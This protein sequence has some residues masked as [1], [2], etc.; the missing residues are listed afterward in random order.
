[1]APIRDR[2]G[3]SPLPS[4]HSNNTPVESEYMR[5]VVDP[6]TKKAGF[7]R[8]VFFPVNMSPNFMERKPMMKKTYNR[9]RK[10]MTKKTSHRANNLFEPRPVKHTARK[11]QNSPNFFENVKHLF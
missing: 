3:L 2:A 1:M 7:K 6:K 5:F 10:N 11:E 9:M 8:Q 4:I